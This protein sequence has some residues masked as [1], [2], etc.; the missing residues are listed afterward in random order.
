MFKHPFITKIYENTIRSGFQKK[1]RG[2]YI[3]RHTHI[4]FN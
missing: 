2:D 4:L 3:F 1:V